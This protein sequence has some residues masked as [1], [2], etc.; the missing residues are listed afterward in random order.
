LVI[1]DGLS[2]QSTTVNLQNNAGY[3]A[4]LFLGDFTKDQIPDILVSIDSGGSGGYGIFY[5]YSS[6]NNM[7]RE[8]FDLEK[9]NQ[10]YKFTVDYEDFYKVRIASP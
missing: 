6:M 2:N 9:Y 7:L 10:E 5:I 4:R 3:N 8:I 1:Q